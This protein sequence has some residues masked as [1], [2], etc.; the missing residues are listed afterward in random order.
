MPVPAPGDWMQAGENT[1]STVRGSHPTRSSG[2]LLPESR[3]LRG[4]SKC[5]TVRRRL[6]LL[7]GIRG[8][9]RSLQRLSPGETSALP[10]RASNDP[11]GPDGLDGVVGPSDPKGSV[12]AYGPRGPDDSEGAAVRI[13]S[14]TM[15]RRCS[16]KRLRRYSATASP[17]AVCMMLHL[18]AYTAED[19]PKRCLPGRQER[20][21]SGGRALLGGY[22]DPAVGRGQDVLRR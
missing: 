21:L 1:T 5:R 19:T 16:A 18:K 3:C 8:N 6:R 20:L 4:E 9:R 22:G 11:R 17:S 13:C 10:V 2:G 15:L 12:R 7:G 14:I